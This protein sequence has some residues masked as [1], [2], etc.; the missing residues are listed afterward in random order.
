M[1]KNILIC[2]NK[3]DIGG[4]ETAVVNQTSEFIDR[5]YRV[6]ILAKR[7]IYT[8]IVED[9]GAIC[10]DINFQL[11]DG[12]D[13]ENS[14]LIEKIIRE[15]DISQVHVH[16]FDCIPSIFPACVNTNTE[17][18]AYIH[19]GV[20]G[21]YDWFEEH[22]VS[23]KSIFN[24]YYNMA[25]KI[26][27][28]TETAKNENKRKYNVD[29]EKYIIRNNSIRFT[30]NITNNLAPNKIEKFL[31]ISRFSEVKR[32][33]IKN[34]INLFKHYKD[35]HIEA[36]LTIVGR[37]EDED[38]VKNEVEDIKDSVNMIGAKN[39]VLE[40]MKDYDVVIAL[41]RCI[42]EAIATKRLAIISGYEKLRGIITHE[43]IELAANENFSGRNLDE[44]EISDIIKELECLDEEKI[45]NIVNK[46]YEFAYENLNIKN[47][48]YLIKDND[49]DYIEI[50]KKRYFEN[51]E[52]LIG[53]IKI[54]EDKANKIYTDSKEAQKYFEEQI[55]IRDN[56]I[57]E[58][59]QEIDK[60]KEEYDDI[61]NKINNSKSLKYTSKV[62]EMLRKF[63]RKKS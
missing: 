40:F 29:D 14:K 51:I 1:S 43:N 37:G 35:N 24:M 57:K 46:N 55:E 16:Q 50:D 5:G 15:Y 20:T 45:A 48:I 41:D 17:Y 53:K 7:G 8:N 19:T 62:R 54:F 63:N 49:K 6:V 39:N 2:L 25:Y 10:I 27:T 58:L 31:I 42:L 36:T 18:I 12:Y 56:Q 44:K 38:F 11:K 26:V 9:K 28:I 23:Y 34:A 52:S 13:L 33:S 4:I 60:V 59:K 32:N 47:N 21:T 30:D 3:L 22:Y 61:N